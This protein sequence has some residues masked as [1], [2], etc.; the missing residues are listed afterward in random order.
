M[1]ATEVNALPGGLTIET[2]S[3]VTLDAQRLTQPSGSTTSSTPK[4]TT[5]PVSE[6]QPIGAP[7]LPIAIQAIPGAMTTSVALVS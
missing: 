7:P 6:Q 1:M 3:T 2:V 5:S 4:V